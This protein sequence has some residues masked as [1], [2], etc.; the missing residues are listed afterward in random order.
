[1]TPKARLDRHEREA[2]T[3]W[4]RQ[5]DAIRALSD[6]ELQAKVQEFTGDD[7]SQ[8]L[9]FVAFL[10]RLTQAELDS[11][12]GARNEAEHERTMSALRKKYCE[13]TS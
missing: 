9:A 8:A 12:D 13:V 2:G 3:R 10:K 1:M 7:P 11:L 6:A 5:H 4:R